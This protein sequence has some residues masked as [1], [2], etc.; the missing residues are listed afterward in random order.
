MANNFF[1]AVSLTGGSDGD[2]DAI[3]ETVISDADIA[4]VVDGVNNDLYMYTAVAASS[5]AESS[6]QW[7][8]P[9]DA[10]T[11]GIRWRMVDVVAFDGT[12]THDLSAKPDTVGTPVTNNLASW[13]ASDDLEDSGLDKAQTPQLNDALE[14]TA[15][16]NFN[17]TT[18]SDGATINWDLAANQVCKVTLGGNRT[19][20]APTNNTAGAVYVLQVI[21]D[22]TGGRTLA[23]NAEFVWDPNGAPDLA[24]A[25]G[26]V[27]IFVFHDDGTSLRGSKFWN[28]S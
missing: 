12:S 19:M 4:C 1:G 20:A 23:W 11:P 27:T 5:Q 13:D 6:P 7:I 15:T 26:D 18:L 21:Q 9:D 3:K 24:N 16:Q 28:E 2:L 10:G 17:E 25:A 8:K 22:G 14:W